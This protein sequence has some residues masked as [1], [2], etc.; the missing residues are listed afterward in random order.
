MESSAQKR[1][2]HW[3]QG[4]LTD[5]EWYP[6]GNISINKDKQIYIFDVIGVGNFTGT[7]TFSW[8]RYIVVTTNDD[9]GGVGVEL[10]L[11]DMILEP[12]VRVSLLVQVALTLVMVG[13]L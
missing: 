5:N 1:V 13:G 2:G 6:F 9:N 11:M 4:L 12:M 7:N 3:G 10:L 8:F